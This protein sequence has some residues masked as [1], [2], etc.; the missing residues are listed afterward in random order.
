MAHA[1][2]TG[3]EAPPL[4][5]ILARAGAVMNVTAAVVSL[6]LIAG[7]AVWGYKLLVR[8]VSGVPVVRALEGPMRVSAEEPGG[9]IAEHSGLAVNT[10]AAA[11]TAEGPR[12][13]V[14]LAPEDVELAE[15]DQPVTATEPQADTTLVAST[16]DIPVETETSAL[17]EVAAVADEPARDPVRLNS[18]A[19]VAMLVEELTAG[20]EPLT[21]LEP[22]T[23][24]SPLEPRV[25]IIPANVPGVARSIRPV[26][27]PRSGASAIVMT[28]SPA[29]VAAPAISSGDPVVQLGA[30]DSPEAAEAEWTRLTAR[31]GAVFEGKSP[32]IQETRSNGRTFYRLRAAGFSDDAATNRFCAALNAEGAGCIPATHR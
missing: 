31:F 12:D 22:V 4:Q 16:A 3:A 6:V 14:V 18:D 1:D 5:S 24:Q 15:D 28:A 23:A 27:R 26:K 8:D 11:G 29:E 2:M 17:T 13:S 21:Q 9:Q 25:E 30:L 32:L 10:V 19:D 7:V 20:V